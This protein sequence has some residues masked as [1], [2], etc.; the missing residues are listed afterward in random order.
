MPFRALGLGTSILKAIEEAGYTE[1][2][3]IQAAVRPAAPAEAKAGDTRN[4][5]RL[6]GLERDRYG[7]SRIDP[8]D[9]E[10]GRD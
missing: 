5:D 3:P 9:H 2:T 7:G 6:D 10:A 4:R 1:P 8:D